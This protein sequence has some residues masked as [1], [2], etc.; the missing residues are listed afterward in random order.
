[1]M[2]DETTS[3][4]ES[5]AEAEA[6]PPLAS[7]PNQQAG[8]K[9]KT[10]KWKLATAI[11]S[12]T[13]AVNLLVA[14]ATWNL[15]HETNRQ[16]ASSQKST[17]DL[18]QK[19]QE[20]Q[21]RLIDIAKPLD[22]MVDQNGR[23]PSSPQ[24][25]SKVIDISHFDNCSVTQKEDGSWILVDAELC[26]RLDVTTHNT[27]AIDYRGNIEVEFSRDNEVWKCT[28]EV[29]T[30]SAN[31]VK[32]IRVELASCFLAQRRDRRGDIDLAAR[33]IGRTEP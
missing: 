30:V 23:T 4:S 1:M 17:A 5:S 32:V 26:Y 33:F 15:A 19:T 6:S 16:V 27:E 10:E 18:I 13:V 12:A 25:P 21:S 8:S 11:S 9:N 7:K 24:S 3:P 28:S 29:R 22:I 20:L 14:L 31:S 2:S